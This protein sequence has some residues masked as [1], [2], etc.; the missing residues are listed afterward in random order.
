MAMVQQ[1]PVLMQAALPNGKVANVD[2]TKMVIEKVQQPANTWSNP[3]LT[4]LSPYHPLSIYHV[5]LDKDQLELLLNQRLFGAFHCLSIQVKTL[6]NSPVAIDGV[7]HDGIELAVLIFDGGNDLIVEVQRCSGDHVRFAEYAAALVAIVD[8][9]LP[10]EFLPC[11]A[12]KQ[13]RVDHLMHGLA[14]PDE[15]ALS[16]ALQL[17]MIERYEARS[18]ALEALSKL[19]HCACGHLAATTAEVVLL[20]RGNHR[21]AQQ[22]ILTLASKCCACPSLSYMALVVVSEALQ[23]LADPS[24]T[25]NI[26]RDFEELTGEDLIDCLLSRVAKADEQ[27]HVAYYGLTALHR[28]CECEPLLR[29]R[30]HQP[31]VE[32]AFR[33]GQ[34]RHSMLQQ[35]SGKLL[36]T[37]QA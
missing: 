7:T 26:F 36:T 25:L 21:D 19:M 28:L 2:Q 30:V 12:A 35:A 31:V 8:S 16:H 10:A 3:M 9:K 22:L 4:R 1:E 6:S 27:P 15:A 29:R 24:L 13:P 33:V 17:L 20:G 34:G 11:Q 37:L 14:L 23:V 32:H 18:S 5:R